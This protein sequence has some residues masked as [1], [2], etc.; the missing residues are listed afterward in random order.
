M[1]DAQRAMLRGLI[2]D[3]AL[4]PPGNAP[5]H[6][7]LAAH[8]D[9]E[10]GALGWM[11][12]RF[13]CPVSRLDELRAALPPARTLELGVILDGGSWTA[14]L[15]AVAAATADARLHIGALEGR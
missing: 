12:G 11:L 4:F 6:E 10:A 9:Y 8:A 15:Q 1:S 3:A 14:D 2:D 13:L 7:A 5:M